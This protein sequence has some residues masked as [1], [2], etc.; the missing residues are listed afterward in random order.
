M[1]V[2]HWHTLAVSVCVPVC[3]AGTAHWQP[4]AT[5]RAPGHWH[6]T[7]PPG[8]HWHSGWYLTGTGTGTAGLGNIMMPVGALALPVA[9]AA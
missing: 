9:L 3:D 4:E 7:G 8:T 1:C 6:L 5:R 2:P